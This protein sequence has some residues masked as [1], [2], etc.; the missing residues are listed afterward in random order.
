MKEIIKDESLVA[1]CGLYCGACKRYLE[2]KC[3]GCDK[4][5]KAT[6][7]K[8]RSCCKENNYRTCADCKSH[9]DPMKCRKFN[10]IFSKIFGLL[11]N[12]DRNACIKRI[13]EI[14]TDKFAEEMTEAKMHSIKK[15][16]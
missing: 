12:S 14:E 10:T 5:E 8:L 3:L 15:R 11:F 7:C 1:Y 4:N 2:D 16:K 9:E 6:W 13:K